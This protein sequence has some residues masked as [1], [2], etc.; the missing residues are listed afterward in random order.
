MI[1]KNQLVRDTFI[2]FAQYILYQIERHSRGYFEAP[3]MHHHGH[4]V[5]L[6]SFPKSGNTWLRFV[7]GNVNALMLGAK[8]ATFRT[9]AQLSPEIRRNR[10]LKNALIV[11]SYP[12][13]LKTH[14]PYTNFFDGYK[15]V[16][17]VRDPFKVIPS[18]FHY[19]RHARGKNLP[20]F[21]RSMFHWRYGFNAWANFLESWDGHETVL[22]RYEDLLINGFE[23][24]R[25]AY[26]T[27]GYPIDEVVLRQALALSSRDKMKKVLAEEGDPHNSNNFN[28]VRNEGENLG[29][30]PSQKEQILNSGRL[31]KVFLSQASKHGYL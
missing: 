25:G 9:I 5:L 13:F 8:P 10:S 24:L 4:N 14:F 12:L 31:S 26:S 20:D 19:L 23:V 6:A 28:F 21:E 3:A 22:L 27:L 7:V 17:V 18:Y 15:S 2:N 30:S 1:T 11:D 16:V 29:F